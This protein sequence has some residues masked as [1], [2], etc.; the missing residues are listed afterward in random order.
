[1]EADIIAS[2]TVKVKDF[3]TRTLTFVEQHYSGTVRDSES[4][5]F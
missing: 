2:G 3:G 1:M 4:F 5:L